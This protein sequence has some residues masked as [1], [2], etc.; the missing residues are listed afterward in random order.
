MNTNKA[1]LRLPKELKDLQILQKSHHSV[2]QQNIFIQWRDYFIAE[3]QDDLKSSHHFYEPEMENYKESEL[4]SIIT[5]FEF[6]LQTYLRK[7][8]KQSIDD[9]V[10][11]IRSFTR[12]NYAKGEL[13]KLSNTP[14]IITHLIVHVN[15]KEKKGKDDKKGKG[16]KQEEK[17]SYKIADNSVVLQPSLEECSEFLRSAFDKM[18]K[19]TNQIKFLEPELMPF[20][21]DQ[22]N[23]N[24]SDD[25]N[26]D[27]F[28][29]DKTIKVEIEETLMDPD[30]FERLG[31]RRG[32]SFRMDNTFEWIKEGLK[33]VNRMIEENI[34]EPNQLLERYKE[35]E[36][37]MKS[38][39][40]KKAKS[41]FEPKQPLEVIRREVEYYDKAY[42]DILNASNDEVEFTIFR[43]RASSVK[44]S[45]A[46]QA[47]R[48][49]KE[50][51][52]YTYEY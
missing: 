7:F 24:E 1:T 40:T 36:P 34:S 2:V 42:Y 23:N 31:P 11:F 39:K 50:I 48:I 26:T 46:D 30:T 49:K 6:I 32:P 17:E 9:W 18:I 25:G 15:K 37:I 28:H 22:T 13:W 5:R 38:S 52:K 45:L 41:L 16:N 10:E 33:E 20:L 8:V 14:M 21:K 4:K 47:D 3:I 51:L 43:V 29:N 19:I 27:S 35:F 12:P 44:K